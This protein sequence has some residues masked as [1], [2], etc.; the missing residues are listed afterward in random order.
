MIP[1]RLEVT[2]RD[3]LKRSPAV[4]LIGP[5]Q[6]GKTTLAIR[7][8]QTCPSVY[9]D[10]EDRLDLQKIRDIAAFHAENRSKLII[11][12]EVHR[13]PDIFAPLRGIIDRERPKGN[14]AGQFLFLGSAAME[15]LR[16]SSESL[17]G[18]LATLELRPI[19]LLECEG[20]QPKK[21]NRLWV[22][23]GGS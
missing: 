19:D 1:R 11:L 17:A 6:V 15:L 5:R 20:K 7:L 9:L 22:R 10:L 18:R 21:M 23:G 13:L 8:S 2:I 16:Q 4:V 3:A 12:D 14:K